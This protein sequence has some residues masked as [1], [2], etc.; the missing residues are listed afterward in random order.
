MK[1]RILENLKHVQ[2]ASR[3][4]A[5]LPPETADRVI[6]DLAGRLIAQSGEVLRENAADLERMPPD[7]PRYDRLRLTVPRL[8]AIAG[9][10]RQVARLASPLGRMLE[11]RTLPNGLQLRK[12]SVPLGVVGIVYEARPNVT[13]DAFA[14]CLKSGNAC[15]LKGGS[16]AR[17]S[18]RAILALIRQALESCGLPADA[19][20]L[21]PPDRQS[22]E[23]ML[24]AVGLIDVVIPR[25]GQAL[26][27]TV[28]R[29]ARVPVIETGAGIVHTYLDRSADLEK[30][31]R[32]IFNAKTRRPSVCN[33]LDCLIVHR[34]RLDDLPFLAEPLGASRVT[35][36][37]D[38][39][40]FRALSGSYPPELLQPAA[41]EH[42][43]T[44][45]LSLQMAVR[46][47]SGLQ[48]ALEHI[49]RYSS[50][51]SEAVLAEDPEVVEQFLQAVDA[52][53]V[54]ANTST[55]FTDGAQFGMGAEI[56]ISTQKLHARGPLALPELTSYKWLI[57]GDGQVRPA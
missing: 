46:T 5:L 19:A 40:A 9:D 37:T 11:E 20:Y 39:P 6:L 56:G 16:D 34:E 52:A 48:E 23:I 57:R 41:P 18:N 17:Q 28:R 2:D 32:I 51:H 44:E 21:L 12:I 42:F 47:V 54:Y 10:L 22:A 53:A 55:A 49:A 31:R 43:G 36:Y 45:F 27:D 30:A 13:V 24:E 4:L 3:Q 26:I 29:L 50:R 35:L 15:V 1:A 33:A 14:L 7:D 8:E 38:L 25:G